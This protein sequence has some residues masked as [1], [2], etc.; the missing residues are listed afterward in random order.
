MVATPIGNL[1]DLS[2]RAREA[3]AAA[4]SDRG[5]GYATHRAIAERNRRIGQAGLAARLQRSRPHRAAGAAAAWPARCIAL[6]SDAGTP[7]LSDPG[8]ALVRAAAAAGIEV[9]AIPGPSA[10]TAAL[11]IA[12]LATDRFAFEGF[13]RRAPASAARRCARLAAEPRTLVFFEAPHRIAAT[14][15][16]LAQMFG[17]ERRAV[18]ARE[19]TKLHET[20]Y[21]GTLR[22]LA[23][24]AASDREFR[25]RRDHARGRGAAA[26][27]PSGGDTR[28]A[29]ACAAAAAAGIAAGARGGDRRPARRRHA[30]R[31]LRSWRCGCSADRRRL[32]RKPIES[33]RKPVWCRGGESA[34][35]SLRFICDAAWRKVRAR[36]A[37]CQVTPGGRE[38][39]ESAT[40]SKPPK[41][42]AT[43]LVRVKRCG[44]SAPRRWQHATA[45]QTPPGAR[46]NR[47]V[48]VPQGAAARARA[49]FRVGRLR[50]AVTR[51]PEE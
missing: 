3:L 12:G 2:P 39:T 34:G 31:G 1:G 22:E 4:R 28:A 24:L 10:M 37:G 48:A 17:D 38:P 26:S 42:S 23:E 35:Q 6:V 30:Q 43:A 47:E 44:K 40:E 33:R 14:L 51:V 20:V 21:R 19:L 11:S 27:T 5:R 25:A 41:R 49:C 18:V 50:R 8:F 7:L 46:P 15:A 45:W 13:C 32:S 16:D 29:G 36:R 9:R